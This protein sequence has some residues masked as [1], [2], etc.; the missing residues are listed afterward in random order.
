MFEESDQA[1][2]IGFVN[3]LH[4]QKHGGIPDDNCEWCK[5]FIIPSHKGPALS[6]F[7]FIIFD[8]SDGNKQEGGENKDDQK[9]Y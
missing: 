5:A 1:G 6:S 9:D 2:S 7:K 8:V 3:S 4:L